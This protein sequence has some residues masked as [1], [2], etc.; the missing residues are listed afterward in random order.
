MAA[1]YSTKLHFLLLLL[2]FLLTNS[3]TPLN[4]SF[5][6]FNGKDYPTICTEG[7]AY[8]DTQFLRLTNSSLD[9]DMKGSVGRA[10]YSRPFLLRE[11]STGKLAD[12]T[13]SFNFAIVSIDSDNKSSYGDGLAFF[14]A[15]NG[16]FIGTKLAAGTT[17]GLPYNFTS[18]KDTAFVAVEFDIYANPMV[19]P[20]YEHVGID[21]NSLNSSIT[22]PW[23]GGI[24]EGK[25]NSATISYNSTSKNLS[26]AFTTYVR[27]TSD[28][29]VMKHF[30]YIIDLKQY[31]PDWVVVGFSASTGNY[32]S[33]NK[34]ISWN[35]NSTSLGDHDSKVGIATDNQT[36]SAMASTNSNRKSRNK[37]IGLAVGLAIGGCAV[38]FGGLVLIRLV[39][40]KKRETTFESSD[41]DPIVHELIDDEFEK[42]AGPRKFSYSEL[43]QAT[44]NFREGEKLGEGGFG[45][46]Y[47]GFIPDLKS[48]VAVKKISRGSKQGLKEYASEVKI[49]SRLRHRNL[50]QL[51]GWCH[52]R[53]FLLVYEFM[54]NGSLD[55]HLFKEQSLLTWDARYKIAQGLASGLLYLHE[56]WE[57]CVLHRDIKSSN[58]MLDSNFNAKLGDFGLARLVDHG[59]QSQTTILAGTMGYMAPDY[60]NTGKASKESD[61][62]SFGVV[63]LEIACGRK[64]IDLPKSGSSPINS[65]EW[66]WELYGEERVIEAADPKLCGDFVEK[67]MECLMTVG[68]WCAHPDYSKRPSIQQAIQ[69][70][71]FEIPLPVLPSKMPVATY[72]DP[73]KSLSMFSTDTS[74]SQ[75]CQTESSNYGHN[76][77]SSEFTTSSLA[78]NYHPSI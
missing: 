62:Y 24:K 10:T 16:S 51:I 23:K 26:V 70:L 34:I 28:T 32:T 18:P 33:L 63:A 4:F 14:I 44:S 48:Y 69:V 52:E 59:K 13:T 65:V 41:E 2:F 19:D 78:T 8:I 1:K 6:R 57:Q 31:L 36:P 35:F 61:I 30:Y 45:R 67:Q 75:G 43:A 56:E 11:N 5:S 50:V 71:N 46:V 54:P 72:F 20:P 25:R 12:F 17:L 49:I 42:G 66:V 3:A 22:R 64:P 9:N 73:P 68:L 7:D 40:W 60:L 53:K 38:L 39:M 29:Q 47:K 55:S 77:N 76:A 21:V 74:G 15:P 58:V 37:S 27:N